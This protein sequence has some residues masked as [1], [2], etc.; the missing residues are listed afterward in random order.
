M[1]AD[2]HPLCEAQAFLMLLFQKAPPEQYIEFTSIWGEKKDKPPPDGKRIHIDVAQIKD[3]EKVFDNVLGDWIMRE[4]R[5]GRD[6][7]FGV[8]PRRTVPRTKDGYPLRSKNEN[9]SH[10][11][12]AWMDYDKGTF[13]AVASEEP[14]P[15]FVVFTG[16]GAHFYWIYPDAV[17]I[18]K[19]VEDSQSLKKKYGGDDTSDPARLLRV[20]GTRNW[21]EPDK[22]LMAAVLN[23]CSN[24][25][26]V[27]VGYRAP[28][29]GAAP[30]V[31]TGAAKTKKSV[32]ALP[33]DL[34][35]VIV[36]GYSA[37][38]GVFSGTDPQTGEVDRSKI[39][40]RVMCSLLDFGYSEDDIKEVFFNKDFGISE[41]VLVDES[42]KGNADHYFHRTY[43]KARLEFQKKSL[44]HEEIG[45]TVDFET[46]ADVRKAPPLEWAIDR[47]LPVG[48]MLIV[49]GPAKSGKSLLVNDMS[50][51]L[52]GVPGKFMDLFEIKKT[53]TV[54]YCQAE[55]S[56]G[57]LDWRLSLI[58]SS[59]DADW[60]KIPLQFLNRSFDLTS[61]KHIYAIANGLKKVKAD[62]LIID[63]LARFHRGD[64][65]KQRD[66]SSVLSN[67][68]RISHETGVLGTI[69]VHHFGK[70]PSDGSAR[71]GV[72]QI[73]GA[74]VIGDWGN[75][76]ILLSKRFNK[77]TG[78][79]FVEISFELR[80]AEEPEPL[81][82]ALNKQIMRFEEYNEDGDRAL[83]VRK[84]KDN[85][86]SDEEKIAAIQAKLKV[87]RA[88][89]RQLLTQEK[90]SQDGNGSEVEKVG[91]PMRSNDAD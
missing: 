60:R 50:I 18:V 75:A 67:V 17:D 52:T 91:P 7:Y 45:E 69:I 59:R 73:R 84:I 53:G 77:I 35:N 16:H 36:S 65:N 44:L 2:N 51:L 20:P 11:V 88:T 24:P 78:K 47:I 72:H 9:I 33:W 21:K 5:G 54:V 37:A 55:L 14:K 12:C 28:E 48:G 42:A 19:A 1:L 10:S 70:P 86:G 26:A 15:T 3:L 81:R 90:F 58:A 46:W 43:D 13:K 23:E 62:Y 34:R 63:P 79:K 22:E 31:D 61:P 49:S 8:C 80:D 27:F 83:T 89:A 39:D 30:L 82:L 71:E 38:E 64:E 41:K 74:S 56:K 32:Y 4:N 66:M 85:E 68:E 29:G 25:D 40:F 57:S 6:V 76:H 87:N